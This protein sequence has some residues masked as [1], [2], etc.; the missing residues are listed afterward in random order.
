MVPKDSA[1]LVPMVPAASVSVGVRNGCALDSSDSGAGDV[2]ASDGAV[3]S[4]SVNLFENKSCVSTVGVETTPAGEAVRSS[5]AIT[6]ELKAH[7]KH[8]QRRMNRV[9]MA[10]Q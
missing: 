2:L 5:A 1:A 9:F 7:A 6:D 4:K 3:V 10:F 8:A